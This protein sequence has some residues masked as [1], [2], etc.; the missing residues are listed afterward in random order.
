MS[1]KEVVEVVRGKH[2]KYE[3]VKKSGGVFGSVKYQVFASNKKEWLRSFDS[4]AD[5][6]EWATEKG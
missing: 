6:V 2:E 4:L 5:A 3:I 1:D